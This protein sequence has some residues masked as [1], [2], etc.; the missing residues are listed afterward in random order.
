V[1]SDFCG[2]FFCESDALN[3]GWCGG[4]V[5]AAQEQE[6]KVNS[7]YVFNSFGSTSGTREKTNRE[8]NEKA[9]KDK[10]A[11][12]PIGNALL[13]IAGA[14]AAFALLKNRNKK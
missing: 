8:W 6:Q 7:Q 5:C 14:V 1:A 2:S 12:I 4:C 10:E 3:Y 11:Q 9:A 13:I